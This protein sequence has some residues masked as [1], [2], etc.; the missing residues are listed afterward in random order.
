[1]NTR[2]RSSAIFA[3]VVLLAFAGSTPVRAQQARL[4]IAYEL[5]TNPDLAASALLIEADART[6]RTGALVICANSP[7]SDECERQA[8]ITFRGHLLAI[9]GISFSLEY[10]VTETDSLKWLLDLKSEDAVDSDWDVAFNQLQPGRSLPLGVRVDAGSCKFVRESDDQP[11]AYGNQEFRATICELLQAQK[12][13]TTMVLSES[14]LLDSKSYTFLVD[15][16]ADVNARDTDGNTV[17]ID[18]ADRYDTELERLL[19]DHGADVSARNKGGSTALM[20]AAF[21]GNTDFVRLLLDH[22]AEINARDRSGMTALYWAEF[23]NK[24]KATA[25]LLR[26]YGATR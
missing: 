18:A 15:H 3:T 11:I 6:Q 24:D 13:A 12:N 14:G 23:I 4:W 2:G 7:N 17:L 16:G 1:M 10:D 8:E 21:Y 22:G 25:A 19:L 26:Q 5:P 20:R 9:P